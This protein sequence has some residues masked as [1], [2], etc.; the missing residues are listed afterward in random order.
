[1][2]TLLSIIA[3][4]LI[5]V[6]FASAPVAGSALAK[7][8]GHE[9]HSQQAAKPHHATKRDD[10]AAQ[11]WEIPTP[12]RRRD[13]GDHGALSTARGEPKGPLLKLSARELLQPTAAGVGHVRQTRGVG[14]GRRL[15]LPP[16]GSVRL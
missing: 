14:F 4:S 15:L 6:A 16:I 10:C 3:S 8:S 1:M 9:S 2:R 5:V 13:A 12:A 11:S 7:S